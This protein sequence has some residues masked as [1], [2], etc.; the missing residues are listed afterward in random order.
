MKGRVSPRF[1]LEAA[2]TREQDAMFEVFTA[3]T[4]EIGVF[5]DITPCIGC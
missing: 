4:M 5:W 1:Y 2:E 3:V